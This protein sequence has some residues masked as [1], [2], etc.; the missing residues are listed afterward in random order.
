[1]RT[2]D[3]AQPR[4]HPGEAESACPREP[5]WVVTSLRDPWPL[6]VSCAEHL[7]QIVS[8]LGFACAVRALDGLIA[9]SRPPATPDYDFIRVVGQPSRSSERSSS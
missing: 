4:A 9:D 3:K 1:M 8:A 5:V 7:S 2:C 6:A